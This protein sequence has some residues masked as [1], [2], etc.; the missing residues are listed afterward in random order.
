MPTQ[1]NNTEQTA[2]DRRG[3]RNGHPIYLNVIDLILEIDAI[4]LSQGECES[5]DERRLV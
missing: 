1:R 2:R 3:L 4:G 5:Q